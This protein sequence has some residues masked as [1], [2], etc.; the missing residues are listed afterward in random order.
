[1]TSPA[2]FQRL[3]AGISEVHAQLAAQHPPKEIVQAVTAQFAIPPEK[4]ITAFSYTHF[5][6][7]VGIE[8]AL[9]CS[10]YEV[11]CLRG[12][13]VGAGIEA[14]ARQPLLRTFRPVPG[15]GKTGGNHSVGG[16]KAPGS[17]HHP[18]PVCFRVSRPQFF[19]KKHENNF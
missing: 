16:G 8:D 7:L 18:R 2:T 6:Q 13:L 19:S 5:E 9:Q 15:Q 1:M 10:F 3:I 4:L 17:L 11:E 14:A 12:K